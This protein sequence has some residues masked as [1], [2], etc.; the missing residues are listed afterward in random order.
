MPAITES[1]SGVKPTK[2]F[3]GGIS[4][5][6]TTKQLRDH[7]SQ[8]GKV[9]DCVAMR[10]PDGRSRGF[11]YVTLDSLSAAEHC[12]VE[13]QV[14]DN[15]IVDLKLAVPE[16]SSPGNAGMTPDL[17]HHGAGAFADYHSVPDM[18]PPSPAGYFHASGGSFSAGFPWWPGHH[19]A[20]EPSSA[21]GG[22]DCV[23]LLSSMRIAPSPR[24]QAPVQ[25][26]GAAASRP[27]HGGI[28]KEE[29]AKVEVQM[30]ASAPEFVP[31][32]PAPAAA[33]AKA[34][35]TEKRSPL[36]EITNLAGNVDTD[37]NES[38]PAAGVQEKVTTA[39]LETAPFEVAEDKDEQESVKTPE[40]EEAAD[41]VAAV[42][43][44]K[45]ENIE[46]ESSEEDRDSVAEYIAPEDL[47]SMGSAL[48]ASG[49]CRRCNFFPKGR[50]GNGKDCT[51][52]HLP[53]E[54]RKPTRQE[55][56]E[57][58]A[59]WLQQQ[60]EQT[61]DSKDQCLTIQTEFEDDASTVCSPSDLINPQSPSFLGLPPV[62]TSVN[63]QTAAP[64]GLATAA[65]NS[66]SPSLAVAAVDADMA[67]QAAM[68][69]MHASA[70]WAMRAEAAAAQS[71]FAFPQSPSSILATAPPSQGVASQ[72]AVSFACKRSDGDILS[73]SP[74][75]AGKQAE[76]AAVDCT[77]VRTKDDML[78]IRSAMMTVATKE[79]KSVEASVAVAT[80]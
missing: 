44:Q 58:Q 54:K 10:Q 66:A 53:H 5:N 52:C 17:F 24:L 29:S 40:P 32:A 9:L 2:L 1:A 15:R 3:I 19:A 75:A 30:S 59:A 60:G 50:C 64:P 51:F 21:A 65:W 43:S 6:T 61:G 26:S 78:R 14:I 62:L 47:P 12:L 80:Q 18:W 71:H 8:H 55:K 68:M 13:P 67:A 31:A 77:I 72:S 45:A 39:D 27:H 33:P 49:D 69:H 7:F 16:G 11:G 48:H 79:E 36:G 46:P 23:E 73:T 4:R 57:R 42:D 63:A 70:A 35:E 22:L 74:T 20:H 76:E 34:P 25:Q 41:C 38:K 28:L 37:K 56:R